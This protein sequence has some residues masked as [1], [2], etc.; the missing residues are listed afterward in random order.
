MADI[1]VDAFQDDCSIEKRYT[2]AIG[3]TQPLGELVPVTTPPPPWS[4]T[5]PNNWNADP[6]NTPVE[7][8]PTFPCSRMSVCRTHDPVH[9]VHCAYPT[10]R[11]Q[12]RFACN[13]RIPFVK[14]SLSNRF[15]LFSLRERGKLDC[16]NRLIISKLSFPYVL[17][18]EFIYFVVIYSV[19][20]SIIRFFLN[21]LR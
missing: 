17:L 18:Y 13:T 5:T 4:T 20:L 7:T 14:R 3:T 1:T 8:V 15:L 19:I 16:F 21:I 9:I 10:E 12:L 2:S 6:V 11:L